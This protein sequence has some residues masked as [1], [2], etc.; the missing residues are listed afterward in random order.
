[1]KIILSR[2]GFD[3]SSGGYPSPILPDGRMFSFPIPEVPVPNGQWLQYQ[4]LQPDSYSGC[5]SYL[6][7]AKKLGIKK[8]KVKGEWEDISKVKVHHDPNLIRSCT[9][10]PPEGWKAIFGQT[11]QA[12]SHLRNE[13]V[14]VGDLFLF[15]GWFRKT[16]EKDGRLTWDGRHLHVIFGYLEVGERYCIPEGNLEPP[17]HL[18]WAKNHPHFSYRDKKIN[19]VYIAADSLSLDDGLAG[20][21][22]FKFRPERRLTKQDPSQGRSVWEMPDCFFAND[23]HCLLTYHKEIEGKKLLNGRVELKTVGRGQEFVV[24][25]TPAIKEWVKTLLRG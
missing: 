23:G 24:E 18:S 2:K 1:M 11:D 6:D 22:I 10:D 7:L 5:R 14:G 19:A 12:Q 21:D 16:K 3:S 17:S 13:H 25:A 8:V 20:A 4:D 9:P 15:F